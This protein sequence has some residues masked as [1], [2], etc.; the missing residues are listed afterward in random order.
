MR[1]YA[2]LE[3]RCSADADAHEAT[4]IAMAAQSPTLTT[5]LEEFKVLLRRLNDRVEARS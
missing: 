1:P 4:A 3:R 2:D 5:V